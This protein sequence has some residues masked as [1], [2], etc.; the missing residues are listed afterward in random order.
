MARWTVWKKRTKF[1]LLKIFLPVEIGDPRQPRVGLVAPF[2]GIDERLRLRAVF[3]ALVVVD[4]EVVALR[5]ERRVDVAQIDAFAVDAVAQD[6]EVVAVIQP[7]HRR[8]LGLAALAC[9]AV[10]SPKRLDSN[11]C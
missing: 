10:P 11:D 8:D 3:A 5:I 6:I 4:L 9:H 1:V 2:P 7:V